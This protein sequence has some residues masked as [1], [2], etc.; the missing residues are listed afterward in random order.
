VTEKEFISHIQDNT[1]LLWKL[2]HLYLQE[3]N[4]KKDMF[5]E[6][7]LQCWAGRNNF[8]GD[9]KVSTWIYKVALFTI[10]ASKRKSAK[11]QYVGLGEAHDRFLVAEGE[12]LTD[13]SEMLYKCIQRLKEVDKTIIT[14]HLDGFPNL[15]IAEFLGI[16]INNLNVKLHRIRDSLK[17]QLTDGGN[18]FA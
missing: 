3:E 6:V 12:C 16:S 13:Q 4:D 5:Q 17:K 18:G 14:M 10:L 7:I 8:R 9:A 15:E 1:G 2:L 11:Q